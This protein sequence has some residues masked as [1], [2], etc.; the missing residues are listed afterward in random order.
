M[1]ATFNR[2]DGFVYDAKLTSAQAQLLTLREKHENGALNRYE[3]E[4]QVKDL[5]DE[6]DMLVGASHILA[7]YGT[8][9]FNFG[10]RNKEIEK[11]ASIVADYDMLLPK[12][13][14]ITLDWSNLQNRAYLNAKSF[15]ALRAARE[16]NRSKALEM[17]SAIYLLCPSDQLGIRYRMGEL[18]IREN[19]FSEC[20]LHL[21]TI[22]KDLGLPGNPRVHYELALCYFRLGIFAEAAQELRYGI[23]RSPHYVEALLGIPELKAIVAPMSNMHGRSAGEEYKHVYRDTWQADGHAFVAYVYNHPVTLSDRSIKA[24]NDLSRF[25]NRGFDSERELLTRVTLASSDAMIQEMNIILDPRHPPVMMRP[26]M[27]AQA[28]E[29]HQPRMASAD[30]PLSP[31]LNV[32][33]DEEVEFY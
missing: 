28:T 9:E 27:I 20:V 16:N 21:K 13:E 18:F 22:D 8:R 31:S 3:Y 30:T 14:G 4:R 23:M 25:S 1:S 12:G 24:A 5:L 17:M 29:K 33:D 11:L 6:N 19:A 7:E 26:W 2:H 15:L 32:A 10:L